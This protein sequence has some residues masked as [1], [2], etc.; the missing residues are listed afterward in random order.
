MLL[1][2]ARLA[3]DG[4]PLSLKEIEHPRD[5]RG[6]ERARHDALVD[7]DGLQ[8]ILRDVLLRHRALALRVDVLLDEPALEDIPGAAE[9]RVRGRLAGDGARDAARPGHVRSRPAARTVSLS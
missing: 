2:L 5:R 3:H 1:Q 4:V 8:V 6:A 9:D 7:L